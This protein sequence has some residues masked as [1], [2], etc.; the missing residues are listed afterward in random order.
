MPKYMQ[1]PNAA[2]VAIMA[3]KLPKNP[4]QGFDRTT[5]PIIQVIIL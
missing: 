4:S 1:K 5:S 2:N 3:D